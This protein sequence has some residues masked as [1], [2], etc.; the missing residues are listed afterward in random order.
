MEVL[1]KRGRGKKRKER[2]EY[3]VALLTVHFGTPNM[4]V[5]LW[6]DLIMELTRH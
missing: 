6:F 4:F 3:T 1:E 5:T 2:R